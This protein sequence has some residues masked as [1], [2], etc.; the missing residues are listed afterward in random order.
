MQ[1]LSIN[2]QYNNVLY[3]YKYRYIILHTNNYLIKIY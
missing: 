2:F 3:N 1:E